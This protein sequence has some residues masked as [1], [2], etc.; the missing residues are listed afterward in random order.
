MNQNKL[1]TIKREIGNFYVK[2]FDKDLLFVIIYGSWAFGLN[3]EDSDIDV[4]GI[5]L[6]YNKKQLR[7]TINFI[8]KIHKKYNLTFDEEVPYEKKLLAT[9]DFMENA[10]R[11][12]G[13]IKSNGNILIQPIVKTKEFLSSDNLAMRLLLNALTTKS[14][15]CGGNY[16][17]YQKIKERS[18]QNCVK[19][20]YSAWNIQKISIESFVDN[21][22]KRNGK[23]GQFYLGFDEHPIVRTY[24]LNTFT[25][26]FGYLEK[27]GRLINIDGEYNIKDLQWFEEIKQK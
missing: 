21:L 12:N 3:T 18:L 11:G 25:K 22:I 15:F 17:I 6:K 24:L 20:F 7:K 13:F 9:Q 4:V 27:E 14:I 2:E 1:N 19:I 10:I 8:K 23:S 5:C 16:K 26:T